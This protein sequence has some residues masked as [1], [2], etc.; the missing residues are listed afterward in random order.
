MKIGV[1][2]LLII[3]LIVVVIFGPKQIPRLTKMFGKSVKN[4]KDG[5]SEED[6]SDKKDQDA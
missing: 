6:D 1:P 2:E 3:L 5:M 4:F